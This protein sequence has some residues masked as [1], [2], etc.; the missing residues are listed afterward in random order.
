MALSKVSWLTSAEVAGTLK[1]AKTPKSNI[2][3]EERKALGELKKDKDL[4]IM[5][6]DKGK[7]TVVQ[8]RTEY[9][10]KVEEML[11]DQHTYEKLAK[12]PTP[13]YKRKLVDILKRLKVEKKIDDSTIYCIPRLKIHLACIVQLKFTKLVIQSAL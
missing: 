13:T 11:S 2:S 10:R 4:F 8:S 12:N 7:C 9:E 6:A 1:L 3:K 5:G